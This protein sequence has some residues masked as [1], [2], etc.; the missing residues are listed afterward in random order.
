MLLSNWAQFKTAGLQPGGDI[1]S[2]F[3]PFELEAGLTVGRDNRLSVARDGQRV[4]LTIG[5]SYFPVAAPIN[6]APDVASA[7][8]ETVPLV[9]AGYGLAVPSVGYDDYAKV[10]VTNKAVLIFS[11]EPQERIRTANSTAHVL[12]RRRPWTQKRRWRDSTAHGRYWWPIPRISETTPHIHCSRAILMPRASR[13]PCCDCAA[14]RCS[15][16]STR[17]GSMRSRSKSTKISNRVPVRCPV[18]R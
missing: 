17:G 13:F 6:D 4:S 5:T 18:E 3:Q 2:W 14:T 16:S 11:H 10:D 9:F 8:L 15:R 12:S 1:R 7:D